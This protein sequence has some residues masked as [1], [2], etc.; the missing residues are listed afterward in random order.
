M[1][2]CSLSSPDPDNLRM[3]ADT[4]LRVLQYLDHG[5][6]IHVCMAFMNGNHFFDVAQH[7][8][9]R[10]VLFSERKSR[11]AGCEPTTAAP[12]KNESHAGLASDDVTKLSNTWQRGKLVLNKGTGSVPYKSML[13]EKSLAGRS[14][15]FLRSLRGLNGFDK[16]FTA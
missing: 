4:L 7:F 16:S 6:T 1:F 2:G 12:S 13:G 14:S 15:V 5:H 11:T 3:A 9:E 10:R 8:P